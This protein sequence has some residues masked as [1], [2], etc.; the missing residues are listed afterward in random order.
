MWPAGISAIRC[1]LTLCVYLAC[2]RLPRFLIKTFSSCNSTSFT[3]R[4][5]RYLLIV[6]TR[7]LF[8]IRSRCKVA[9]NGANRRTETFIFSANEYLYSGRPIAVSRYLGEQ[10]LPTALLPYGYRLAILQFR[11]FC[12]EA[13]RGNKSEKR[14]VKNERRGWTGN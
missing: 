11:H 10:G 12:R 14:R 5:N 13:P 4:E 1:T 7:L 3:R 6:Y 8:R 9:R 2:R